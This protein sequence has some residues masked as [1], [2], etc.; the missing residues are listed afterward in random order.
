MGSTEEQGSGA[1]HQSAS[2]QLTG[3]PAEE[4][5]FLETGLGSL[6]F[7]NLLPVLAILG[8]S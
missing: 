5:A 4:T 3:H 6:S 2:S 8:L 7:L 1:S